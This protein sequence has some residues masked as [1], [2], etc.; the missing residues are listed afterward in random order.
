MSISATRLSCDYKK[1][2]TDIWIKIESS[3]DIKIYCRKHPIQ[4][5]SFKNNRNLSTKQFLLQNDINVRTQQDY[6]DPQ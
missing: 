1:V 4:V 5:K 2:V 3:I 6:S